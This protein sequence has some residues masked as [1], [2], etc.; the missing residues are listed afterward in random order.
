MWAEEELV[1]LIHAAWIDSQ[2][3]EHEFNKDGMCFYCS[4]CK[5]KAGKYK[6][7]TYKYCPWCGAKMDI[8]VA[9]AKT[10][11]NADTIKTYTFVGVIKRGDG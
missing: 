3:N 2:P 7:K 10:I 8:P 9:P 1:P 5:H 6:H 11:K 4:N